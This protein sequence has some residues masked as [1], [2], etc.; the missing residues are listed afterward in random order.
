MDGDAKAVP[1]TNTFGG[2]LGVYAKAVAAQQQAVK[3]RAAYITGKNFETD[4][5]PLIDVVKASAAAGLKA[6]TDT[7]DLKK[8]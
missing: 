3:D 1:P 2:A 6:Q 5:K 4:T 8:I 7:G